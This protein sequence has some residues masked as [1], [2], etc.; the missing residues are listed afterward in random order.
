MSD[1][2]SG[3]KMWSYVPV[4]YVI[5]PS[6]DEQTFERFGRWIEEAIEITHRDFPS[7]LADIPNRG[8][9]LA[10]RWSNGYIYAD[11]RDL[12]LPQPFTT[13]AEHKDV[14]SAGTTAWTTEP[15]PVIKLFAEIA[16]KVPRSWPG[17]LE[18]RRARRCEKP[19]WLL[20][21]IEQSKVARR[22]KK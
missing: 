4:S 14:A 6:L 7:A 10:V 3:R 16:G 1:I 21:L 2:K 8:F 12:S 15:N 11:L 17:W 9:V 5:H 19:E 20:A 13:R 22:T 18:W